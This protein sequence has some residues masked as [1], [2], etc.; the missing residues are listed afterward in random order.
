MNARN[1]QAKASVSR[2]LGLSQK[3]YLL[4][5][6]ITA[7]VGDLIWALA[8]GQVLYTL[9]LVNREKNQYRFIGECYAHGLMDREILRRLQLGEARMD[10]ISLI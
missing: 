7:V 3:M 9:R 1:A 2:N 10:D 8:G 5:V 6:P 4:M